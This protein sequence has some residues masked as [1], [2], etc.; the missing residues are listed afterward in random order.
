MYE[1]ERERERERER[2]RS[3]EGGERQ[4]HQLLLESFFTVQFIAAFQNLV[5]N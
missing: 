4:R 2:K 3:G 1:K 5:T